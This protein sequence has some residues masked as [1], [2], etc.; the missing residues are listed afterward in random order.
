MIQGFLLAWLNL[1]NRPVPRPVRQ[2][3]RRRSAFANALDVLGDLEITQRLA[4]PSPRLMHQLG[5]KVQRCEN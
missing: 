2:Q 4:L 5:V 3:A 1:L